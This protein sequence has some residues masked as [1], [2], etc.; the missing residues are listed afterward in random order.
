MTNIGIFGAGM[1]ANVHAETIEALGATVCAVCDS[2]EDKAVAFSESHG[3]D[4][5]MS[6]DELLSREEIDG[7]V[8]AVPNDMHAHLAIASLDAGKDVLLEKP[9]AMSLQEC[10]D[11][12]AAR[13]SSNNL[14]QLGFVCRYSPAAIKAKQLID[15]GRIGGVYPCTCNSIATAGDTRSGWVGL[16]INQGVVAGA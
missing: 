6:V 3:C 11:I 1:I 2:C 9:M 12:I 4:V 8:I 7:I 10:D 5:A 14:L 15:E 16:R 13:N